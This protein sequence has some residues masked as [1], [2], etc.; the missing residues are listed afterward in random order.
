MANINTSKLFQ[1][2]NSDKLKQKLESEFN[3]NLVETKQKQFQENINKQKKLKSNSIVKRDSRGQVKKG[4]P[5]KYTDTIYKATK[6]VKVSPLNDI[7]LRNLTGTYMTNRSRDE[8][9][10]E[11]LDEYIVSRLAVEDKQVLYDQVIKEANLFREKNP[12]RIEYDE[13]GVPLNDENE[14]I[15][16]FEKQLKNNWKIR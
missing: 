3:N 15:A 5:T 10:R 9:M 12:I 1:K 14:V 16:E 4:A 8:I 2:S 11:A 13:N 6:P 7:I